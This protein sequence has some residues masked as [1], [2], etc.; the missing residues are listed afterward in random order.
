MGT[1]TLT[2]SQTDKRMDGR[3][4][5]CY[6]SEVTTVAAQAPVPQG[7]WAGGGTDSALR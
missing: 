5:G 3:T 4:D 7:L 1:S 2:D 6:G